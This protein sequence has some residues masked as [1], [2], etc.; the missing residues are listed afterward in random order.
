MPRRKSDPELTASIAQRIYDARLV[1]DMTQM[2]LAVA[3]GTTPSVISH[4]ENGRQI[5]A[6]EMLAPLCE[7]LEVTPNYLLGWED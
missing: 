1:K 4:W 2:G 5:P 3:M 6:T 7:A